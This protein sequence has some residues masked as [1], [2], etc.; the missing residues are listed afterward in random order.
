MKKRVLLITTLV[1]V[2]IMAFTACGSAVPDRLVGDWNCDDTPS[3]NN[4][5]VGFYAMTIE[6]NGNFSI[7]D[8]EAGNPGISGTMKGDDTGKLV[9]LELKCDT[10]DFDPPICWPNLKPNSRVRYKIVDENTIK[11]GYVGIWMTFRK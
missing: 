11:L 5:Y 10:E 2:A 8:A 3:G 6:S 7:Y 1:I 9:I 4:M